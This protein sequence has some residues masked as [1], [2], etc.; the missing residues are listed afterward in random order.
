MV[1]EACSFIDSF[2]AGLDRVFSYDNIT[3]VI[4]VLCL[5]YA[6]YWINKIVP[7]LISIKEALFEVRN[8]ITILNERLDHK[9]Y[10]KDV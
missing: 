8:S 4:L 2:T 1:E 6:G 10:S 5:I 9:E 7:V 3:I